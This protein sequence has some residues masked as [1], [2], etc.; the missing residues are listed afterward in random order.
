[1][2]NFAQ[3][4]ISHAE[5]G[6]IPPIKIIVLDE[7]DSMT[8]DA[9]SALRRTMEKYSNT[10]RFCLI[11]NYASKIIDPIVSRCTV[12]RFKP[13]QNDLVKKTLIDICEK[14]G[15]RIS[16]TALNSLTEISEGDLRRSITLLQTAT[17]VTDDGEE[18]SN[19]SICE[20]SGFIP[21]KEIENFFNICRLKSYPKML[22]KVDSLVK[23]GYSGSQFFTQLQHWIATSDESL[24]SDE[25][26]S[27]ISEQVALN[28]K[29]L[30][31]G[32]D[33]YLQMAQVGSCIIKCLT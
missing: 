16:D 31:D 30:L 12:F 2:K 5:D 20:I 18:I 17:F 9:Q 23:L 27:Q 26:K 11:C 4:T 8:R 6:K 28:D 33:E 1:M 13:L 7:C 15:F 14:E 24:L 3:K 10:T 19:E 21:A 32:C 29:R 22:A 25:Q